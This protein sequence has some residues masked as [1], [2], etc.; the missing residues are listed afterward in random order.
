MRRIYAC[1]SIIID[2]HIQ[3]KIKILNPHQ[4][5]YP[6]FDN[7]EWWLQNVKIIIFYQNGANHQKVDC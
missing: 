4:F 1:M 5:S 6:F 2:V 3:N 7:V